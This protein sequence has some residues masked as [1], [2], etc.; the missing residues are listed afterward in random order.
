MRWLKELNTGHLIAFGCGVAATLIGAKVV[1]SKAARRCTVKAVAKGLQ[2]RDDAQ[3]ALHGIKE[4]AEDIYA[5]AK[6]QSEGCD[7][8]CESVEA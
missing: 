6:Q 2:L 7:C 8:G 5:E 1:K 3:H 4:E